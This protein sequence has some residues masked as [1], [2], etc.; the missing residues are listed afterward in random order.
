MEGPS[1]IVLGG[2]EQWK[3]PSGIV[4]GGVEQVKDCQTL[5]PVTSTAYVRRA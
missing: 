2:V 4:L 1:D 5:Q 3:V